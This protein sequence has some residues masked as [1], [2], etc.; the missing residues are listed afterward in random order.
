M[1]LQNHKTRTV[2]NKDYSKYVG[3]FPSESIKKAGF[4]E[5]DEL[6]V[7]SQK[8]KIIIKKKKGK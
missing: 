4:K 2:G 5:G 6:E 3:V 1:K 8:G 7:K